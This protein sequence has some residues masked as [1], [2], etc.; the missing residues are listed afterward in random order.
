MC[1]QSAGASRDFYL[2]HALMS[3]GGQGLISLTPGPWSPG[4]DFMMTQNPGLVVTAL[5]DESDLVSG[6]QST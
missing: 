3:G 5:V 4:A 2:N 1:S 6:L